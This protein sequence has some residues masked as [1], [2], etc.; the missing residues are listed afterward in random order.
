M[1]LQYMLSSVSVWVTCMNSCQ[2]MRYIAVG[3]V[4]WYEAQTCI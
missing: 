1:S 3:G 2:L 4:V